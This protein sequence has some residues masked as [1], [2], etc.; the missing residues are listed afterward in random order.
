MSENSTKILH[1][2]NSQQITTL[3]RGTIKL[4][5]AHEKNFTASSKP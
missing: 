5:Q 3:Y 1:E 2:N 4:P